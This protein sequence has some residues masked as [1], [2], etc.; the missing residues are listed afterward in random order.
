VIYYPSAET[1][2]PGKGGHIDIDMV[3]YER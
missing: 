3:Y 1:S 2:P